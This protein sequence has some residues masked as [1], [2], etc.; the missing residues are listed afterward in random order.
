[1]VDLIRKPTK[2]TDIFTNSFSYVTIEARNRID[3][4]TSQS[5]P[6]ST[7]DNKLIPN[8]QKKLRSNSVHQL[9]VLSILT[10]FK[11]F[12]HPMKLKNREHDPIPAMMQK[13]TD[14]KTKPGQKGRALPAGRKGA[15]HQ[16]KDRLQYL[17]EVLQLDHQLPVGLQQVVP[18]VVLARV[19]ALARYLKRDNYRLTACS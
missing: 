12:E 19:Y 15:S 3:S 16:R 18:E 14:Q 9:E 1:M 2:Y 5:R 4:Q 8:F 6:N 7:I 11:K 17:E 13:E 10:Y